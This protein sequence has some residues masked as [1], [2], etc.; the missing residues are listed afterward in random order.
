[1]RIICG[2]HRSRKILGPREGDRTTRP[3]LDRVKQALFDRLWAAGVFPLADEEGLIVP[4]GNVVDVFSGT[5]SLGLEAL[6]RGSDHCTFIERD[7]YAVNALKQ[8]LATLGLADQATVLATDAL[9]GV[10]LG[11]LPKRPV[12][13]VFLDPPYDV[14]QPAQTAARTPRDMAEEE[15]EV[16]VEGFESEEAYYAQEERERRRP[17]KKKGRRESAALPSGP[18]QEQRV[19]DLIA[20]IASAPGV[21]EPQG[22]L[23]LRVPEGVAPR[24]VAGWEPPVPH[25]YGKMSLLFYRKG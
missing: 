22:L 8:N 16:V 18:S 6:S 17:A 3:I 20:S 7:S 12:R 14:M 11:L 19:W 9:A 25:V 4:Q 1:M 10:W 24:T 21:M 13:V 2:I 15:A 5:G 23:V